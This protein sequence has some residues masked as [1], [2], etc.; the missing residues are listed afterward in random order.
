MGGTQ[1]NL[2]IHLDRK[3]RVLTCLILDEEDKEK[4]SDKW[5]RKEMERI[6]KAQRHSC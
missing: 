5:E 1:R 2:K 4:A 3:V 6:N